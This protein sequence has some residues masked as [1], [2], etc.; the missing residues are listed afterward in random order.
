MRCQL[1]G[2]GRSN[3]TLAAASSSNLGRWRHSA[4]Y[5][6]TLSR[7]PRLA[8]R[9]PHPQHTHSDSPVKTNSPPAAPVDMGQHIYTGCGGRFRK[10]TDE[11]GIRNSY[12][13]T[14]KQRGA[15]GCARDTRSVGQKP[16]VY[17]ISQHTASEYQTL[18]PVRSS[19]A[20]AAYSNQTGNRAPALP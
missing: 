11:K 19:H 7:D 3:D 12:A 6:H 2:R 5:I 16:N 14:H 4:L 20:Q 15:C 1:E 13:C 9:A 17:R 10:G 8:D 18:P